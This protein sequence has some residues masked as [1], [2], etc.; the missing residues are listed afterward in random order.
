MIIIPEWSPLP[1]HRHTKNTSHL[2]EVKDAT[3]GDTFW[4]VLGP[5]ESEPTAERQLIAR[6]ERCLLSEGL[7]A[8]L[9]DKLDARQPIR[10][11]Q[12]PTLSPKQTDRLRE[13]LTR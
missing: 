12:G 7:T 3:K 1:G 5:G 6:A 11:G 2:G 13:L 9:R 4:L 8:A 10:L